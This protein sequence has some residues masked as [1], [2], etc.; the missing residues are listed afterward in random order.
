MWKFLINFAENLVSARDRVFRPVSAWTARPLVLVYCVHDFHGVE[1][2]CDKYKKN[3]IVI[4]KQRY[5]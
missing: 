5:E 1:C 3:Y 2:D 4:S